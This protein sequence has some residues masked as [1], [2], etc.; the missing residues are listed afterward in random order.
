MGVLV[1]SPCHVL[2]TYGPLGDNLDSWLSRV[3]ELGDL[4]EHGA[5]WGASGG[6]EGSTIYTVDTVLDMRYQT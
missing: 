2:I 6:S 4:G 3:S 5:R 1:V